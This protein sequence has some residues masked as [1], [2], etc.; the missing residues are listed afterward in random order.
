MT[1][2]T[3]FPEID[4]AYQ[5]GDLD[6][7]L[8]LTDACLAERPG[9]DATHELRARALLELGRLDEAE[10]HV[11][12]AVRIDPDEIR[13]RELLAQVLAQRGAHRDAAAEFGR[14]ARNDPRQA[15]WTVAEARERLGSGQAEMS[16][17]A[18][19]R[20]VRLDSRNADAQLAL[21]RALARTGDARGA[22][23]AAA[24]AA[25]LRPGDPAVREASAD[26]RW[27]ANRDQEAFDEYRAL[28][29]ELGGADRERVVEKARRLYRQHAGLPG[30]SIAAW[31]PLFG[32]LLS[33]GWVAPRSRRV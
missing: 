30:R 27:I 12:D 18:A 16:V 3:S 25:D 20:A 14:L 8:R 5:R 23:Q 32:W 19:Q 17:E 26:A 24:I 31:R 28:A 10:R 11:S 33:R 21:A 1:G 22:Q 9:D 6:E 4:A 29:A 7:V 2:T 13:Y 15:E